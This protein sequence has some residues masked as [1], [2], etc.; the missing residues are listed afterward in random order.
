[1]VLVLIVVF[2][3]FVVASDVV[4]GVMAIEAVD[5]VIVVFLNIIGINIIVLGNVFFTQ[6]EK[7]KYKYYLPEVVE[8]LDEEGPVFVFVVD[9]NVALVLIIV[10]VIIIVASDVV[11]GVGRI[12]AVG[13]VTVVFLN[14]I[15]ISSH[16][17]YLQKKYKNLYSLFHIKFDR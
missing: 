10:F 11:F 2:I 14:I 8:R 5:F 17:G 3:I 16:N 7:S 13:G 4:C 12:E 9:G 1:M 6:T 15:D